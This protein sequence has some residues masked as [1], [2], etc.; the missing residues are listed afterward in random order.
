[1]DK[2]RL[3]PPREPKSYFGHKAARPRFSGLRYHSSSQEPFSHRL[4]CGNECL[5]DR[6]FRMDQLSDLAPSLRRDDC[7]FKADIQDAYY[8]LRLRKEGQLYLSFSV[9][10]VVYVP[11]C[12]T[13]GLAVARGSLPRR[14]ARSSPSSGREATEYSPTWTTSSGPQK[15]RGANIR[16]QSRIHA[17]WGATYTSC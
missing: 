7:L 17:D 14:C 8:H 15:L 13:C 6:T 4:H 12:L 10:G 2:C 9:D 1:M 3:L 11:A 5:E 16:R